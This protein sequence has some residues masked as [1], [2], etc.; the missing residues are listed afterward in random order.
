MYDTILDFDFGC[1]REGLTSLPYLG[2]QEIPVQV[3][4]VHDPPEQKEDEVAVLVGRDSE[5]TVSLIIFIYLN[6]FLFSGM[7]SDG[8]FLFVI[9]HF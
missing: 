8:C 3:R 2:Y 7:F 1:I 5:G 4:G 9:F 6:L